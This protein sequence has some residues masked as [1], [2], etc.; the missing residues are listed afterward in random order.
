M[1]EPRASAKSC[2]VSACLDVIGGKWKPLLIHLVAGGCNRFGAMSRAV[3]SISK[4]VLTRQLRE[5]EEHGLLTRSTINGRVL[6]VEYYLT[7]RGA[8][9]IPVIHA[10]RDWGERNG[11]RRS[12]EVATQGVDATASR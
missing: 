12:N 11:G 5:L 10:M 8:S 1:I 9:V 6:H 7:E 4:Q 3:P 2:A